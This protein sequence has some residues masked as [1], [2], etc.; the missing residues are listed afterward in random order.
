MNDHKI[1]SEKSDTAV[2]SVAEQPSD[3][4]IVVGVVNRESLD[5]SILE[6]RYELSLSAYRANSTLGGK[7][8]IIAFCIHSVLLE[9]VRVYLY[10]A[11]GRC[12]PLLASTV[13]TCL[14]NGSSVDAPILVSLVSKL[15]KRLNNLAVAAGLFCSLDLGS[16]IRGIL[17]VPTGSAV[18]HGAIERVSSEAIWG[19]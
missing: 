10:L 3:L 7:Q 18:P 9:F 16:V 8:S 13:S 1:I 6:P 17:A 15:L 14:A 19:L 4:S 12:C 2:A 5:S 11:V